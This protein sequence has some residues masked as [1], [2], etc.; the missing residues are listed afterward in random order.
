MLHCP[1]R[2]LGYLLWIAQQGVDLGRH[3]ILDTC[4]GKRVSLGRGPRG[5]CAIEGTPALS[6]GGLRGRGQGELAWG[7]LKQAGHLILLAARG[8][9]G[10]RL[11]DAGGTS[12]SAAQA[13]GGALC[14]GGGSFDRAVLRRS[15]KPAAAK[16]GLCCQRPSAWR[17]SLSTDSAASEPRAV[18]WRPCHWGDIPFGMTYI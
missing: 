15:L 10:L 4:P 3:H 12:A 18:R 6:R 11:R 9:R 2:H 13:V 5:R 14:E 16:A 8:P 7:P 17:C 1:M